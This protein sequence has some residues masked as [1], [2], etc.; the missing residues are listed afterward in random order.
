MIA[1]VELAVRDQDAAI[2][3]V[4]P[5]WIVTRG[6]LVRLIEWA[7]TG[8]VVV[9]P[10]TPWFSDAARAELEKMAREESGRRGAM[11]IDLGVAYRLYP[12]GVEPGRLVVFEPPA[13]ALEKAR[14]DSAAADPRN[15]FVS[16]LLAI[17]GVQPPVAVSDDRLKT[18]AFERREG[19][20]GLFV[21]N[22]S[23]RPVAAELFFPTRV[24]VS[25]LGS[26][27]GASASVESGSGA[28]A[29]AQRASVS[30]GAGAGAAKSGRVARVALEVP[31]RGVF[32]IAVDGLD[33]SGR[34]VDERRQAQRTEHL[35]R[36][37][38]FTGAVH[39]LPGFA[40]DGGSAWI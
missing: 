8:R 6:M 10:R 39:E 11:E 1:S 33:A 40:P 32:P 26:F 36:E 9:F 17:A 5:S 34:D 4:D 27:L 21:L 30:A 23:A 3:F 19:G 38:A 37:A 20:L 13:E 2:L 35:I 25:D 22:S 16:S 12:L 14:G 29:S 7:K 15:A 31:G 24:L 28:W 18:L